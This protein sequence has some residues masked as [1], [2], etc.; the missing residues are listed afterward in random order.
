MQFG[1]LWTPSALEHQMRYLT[2]TQK[3]LL[4]DMQDL[5]IRIPDLT[6]PESPADKEGIARFGF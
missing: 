4:R 6:A 1:Y 2:L 5:L 3:G